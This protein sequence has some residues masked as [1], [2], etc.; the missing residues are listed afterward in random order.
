M[1][2]ISFVSKCL[3]PQ[4]HQQRRYQSVSTIILILGL[5]FEY[6]CWYNTRLL[7]LNLRQKFYFF[8]T[9][10]QILTKLTCYL[11]IHRNEE[12]CLK[13][14][15]D[16]KWGR[17]KGWH[18]AWVNVAHALRGELRWHP[19]YLT[20]SILYWYIWLAQFKYL[21]SIPSTTYNMTN[22]QVQEQIS[23][24]LFLKYVCCQFNPCF[25]QFQQW[26]QV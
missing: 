20:D 3:S 2:N 7:G 13:L 4:S 26:E 10:G 22:Y 24:I 23:S 18:A 5:L 21:D 12:F 1:R 11:N 17:E 9:L 19:K 14:K 16:M 25:G 15:K 6:W 8:D